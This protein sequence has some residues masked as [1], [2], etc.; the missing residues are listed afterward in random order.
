MS[1]PSAAWLWT[2]FLLAGMAPVSQASPPY[3]ISPGLFDQSRPDLG[4][5]SA[6]GA[7]TVSIF[8]PTDGSDKFSN[9]AVL[10]P[11]KGRL[12]AQWQ[13]SPK[14]EDSPDTWVAYSVSDDGVTWSAPKVLAA[15]GRGGRMYSSGGWWS[16]GRTL[17][18]Y[19]NVWPT[20]FQSGEGGFTE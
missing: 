6:P 17:I 2:V 18:A 7:Q 3:E 15:A 19:I 1:A 9:G 10:M 20:G 13:S 12:Y 14:D 4:L 16:D 5:K 11:F 8:K